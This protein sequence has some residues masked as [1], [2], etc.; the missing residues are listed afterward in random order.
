MPLDALCRW[1]RR[2][3]LLLRRSRVERAMDEE[4]RQHI[5]CET[6]ELVSQGLSAQ[7]AR[8]Q[9]LIDFGGLE[10]F[11]EEGRDTRGVRPFED[12]LMDVRHAAR[13]LR[14][15]P[16][17]TLAAVLTF[18]LGIGAA[19]AIFS[20]VYGVLFRP[21]PY[22][23]PER[24][25][26]I[27]ERYIPSGTDRNVVALDN[28]EAWRERSRT[29]Q[30][31]AALVPASVTVSGASGA[32]R[33]PGAEV[34][35]GYFQLLGIAPAFGRE[36]TEREAQA[37]VDVVMLSD[38]FWRRRFGGDPS[39]V[40]RVI[41]I[42]GK[43]H[44]IVGILPA[45]FD[46]PRFGWLGSQELWFPFR[47]NEDKRSW[48][49]A[50][51]VMGR[52]RPEV[53]IEQA[54]MEMASIGRRLSR[55]IKTNEG[56]SVS[57]VGLADQISGEARS[58]LLL[59]ACG[60][61][62]LLLMA[63]ANVAT[64]TLNAMLRRQHEM[65]IRRAIGAGTGRLL[66]QLLTQ[67]AL[68]A[69]GGAAVGLLAATWGVR[70]LLLRL[71]AE[72]PR[73]A[74]IR[75]D[76]PVLLFAIGAIVLATLGFGCL[77]AVRALARG[78]AIP[79]LRESGEARGSS[80]SGG[81]SLVTAEI[82][83]GLVLSV[84]AGLMARS[85]AALRAVDLGF[86]AESVVMARV[87]LSGDRYPTPE[88]RR[89]FFAE[90]L[91]SLRGAPGVR[92]AATA[93]TRPFG[94]LGP[95]TSVRDASQTPRPGDV[96]T[97]ADIRY[98]D[99]EYFHALR[100]PVE[101]GSLFGPREPESGDPRVVISRSTAR[102]LWRSGNAIGKRVAIDLYGGLTAEVVGVV[103]D[104]HLLD[105]RT[106]ARPAAYLAISRFPSEVCD[107]IV[108]GPGRSDEIAKSVRAAVSRLDS[109]LP[110]YRIATLSGLVE[111][112]LARD[113]FTTFLL[114]VFACAALGL[115]AVGIYGVFAGE[116]AQRRKEIGIRAA[117]GARRSEVLGLILRQALAPAT[118]GVLIGLAAAFLLTRGMA[119]LLFE[120][121]ASDPLS[122]AA[123]AALLLGV[124]LAATL[125]PALRASRVSPLVALRG[126]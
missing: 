100:I 101:A 59:L 1:A 27:W 90:L 117:L 113:R 46:P 89:T 104:V 92:S 42:G 77:A 73:A 52:L 74:S 20:V 97:T 106:P 34:S 53:R 116:V 10:R 122:Y 51:L 64:L 82:A 96:P 48:G 109:G 17:F 49:R 108:R 84:L 6:D 87:T 63:V 126:E 95:A 107:V 24:L 79:A 58:S 29:F 47:A 13:S 81:R 9:A 39:A 12:F 115:A 68:L 23:D 22:R 67:S 3:R 28:F 111:E 102:A 120:V 54:R 26:V 75:V 4:M 125:I 31:M 57:V 124:S 38:G 62:L 40:G 15:S 30:S 71:P 91:E 60:V 98:V 123:V 37:G 35:A 43:P 55:E 76:G 72:V 56:W 99:P 16:G 66:R 33:V 78:G 85:L 45:G 14:R 86:D 121:R 8:R 94:G 103:G 41:A 83:V 18:A 32:E 5:E 80:R 19:T 11:K 2:L 118:R 44:E 119:S 114:E 93:S 112:S 61:G 88:A 110:V 36:F 70:L 69:A 25:A 21:L 65:A 50:L 7:E 105:A